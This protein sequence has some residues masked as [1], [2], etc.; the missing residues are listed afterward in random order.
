MK[1]KESVTVAARI[2]QVFDGWAALEQAGEH[3]KPVIER[4]RLTKG[5]FGVGRRLTFVHWA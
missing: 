5:P 4:T 1:L 2:T 3:Q